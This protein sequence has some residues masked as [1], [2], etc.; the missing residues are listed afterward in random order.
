[1]KKMLLI[2]VALTIMTSAPVRADATITYSVPA[3]QSEGIPQQAFVQDGRVLVKNAGNASTDLVFDP[4]NATMYVI[5]H[6]NAS[7]LQL[8]EAAIVAVQEQAS[9]LRSM[10]EQQLQGLPPEQRAQAEKMMQSMGINTAVAVERPAPTLETIGDTSFSG[11]ECSEKRVMEG[12][13][14][15]A[16]VCL[17]KGNNLGLSDSDYQALL[18]MQNFTFRLASKAKD[19]A[20]QMGNS[21]P[22]FS[23]E[24]LDDL[25]IQGSDATGGSASSMN[26][27]GIEDG[28][29]PEGSTSIPENYTEQAMPSLDS[30]L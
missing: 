16:T 6:A 15:I 23:G 7:Y 17:S 30:L 24:D 28:A 8:N 29:L 2:P 5:D 18:G 22:N 11:F 27:T 13:Q 21:I 10:M 4:A 1:M 3:D 14:Q 9:G 20:A 26:I 19:L 25:I 12:D